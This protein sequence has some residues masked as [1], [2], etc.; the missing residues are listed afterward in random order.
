MKLGSST[1]S[2]IA[3]C[4]EVSR[5]SSTVANGI[6]CG[7]LEN[8]AVVDIW[9]Q[10]FVAGVEVISESSSLNDDAAS[11]ILVDSKIGWEDW[12]SEYPLG[13][14]KSTNC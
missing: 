9:E 2:S 13:V 6:L 12:G 1:S 3:V 4:S 10:D 5:S 14:S 11:E 7:D 8:A